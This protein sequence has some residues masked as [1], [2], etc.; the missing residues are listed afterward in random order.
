M[1]RLDCTLGEEQIRVVA[2][3]GP[4]FT[5]QP[6]RLRVI[7]VMRVL[8]RQHQPVIAQGGTDNPF[9]RHRFLHDSHVHPVQFH[10][11]DD[12][13]GIRCPDMHVDAFERVRGA[14]SVQDP[15]QQRHRRGVRH[16]EQERIARLPRPADILLRLPPLRKKLHS[17]TVERLPRACRG[18]IGTR[19][20]LEQRCP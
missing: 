11:F 18:H 12:V 16:H 6:H 20:P 19:M 2:H 13:V 4:V 10:R 5:Q 8:P 14:Q 7:R 3:A 1:R 17:G 9:R 15:R